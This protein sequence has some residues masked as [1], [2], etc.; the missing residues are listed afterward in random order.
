MPDSSS[1]CAPEHATKSNGSA[2]YV[3]RPR[4]YKAITLVAL[5]SEFEILTTPDMLL[6]S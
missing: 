6:H 3:N 5:R 1:Q 4:R 2:R